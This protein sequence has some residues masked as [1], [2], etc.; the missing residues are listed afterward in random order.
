M[1]SSKQE[2]PHSPF[3]IR[4]SLF[5]P[6][7]RQRFRAAERAVERERAEIGLADKRILQ[8]PVIAPLADLDGAEGLQV[9]GDV[10]GVE[11]PVAAGAQARDQIHQRDLGGVARAVEHTLAEEGAAERDAVKPAHQRSPIIDLS[12][13]H[14]SEPTRL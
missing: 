8:Q 13:I 12:L 9:I 6:N 1:A 7:Y 3:V 4:Y 2:F 11:Q 14:I 5:A 10:L